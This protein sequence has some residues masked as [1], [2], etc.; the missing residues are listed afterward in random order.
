M[1]GGARALLRP[2]K[3]AVFLRKSPKPRG[4]KSVNP[5]KL[6][7]I[8]AHFQ[9]FLHCICICQKPNFKGLRQFCKTSSRWDSSQI[10][11]ISSTRCSVATLTLLL[12]K[13]TIFHDKKNTRFIKKHKIT[14]A[15]LHTTVKLPRKCIA[16]AMP[17]T[18]CATHWRWL[19]DFVAVWINQNT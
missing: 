19:G 9:T 17:K 15:N 1:G 6:T 2:P 10:L 3:T 8:K 18:F 4:S 11:N 5:Q 7:N 13:I 14:K 16:Y 12:Q